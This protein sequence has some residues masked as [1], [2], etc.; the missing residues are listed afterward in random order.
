MEG[1]NLNHIWFKL[2]PL[3]IFTWGLGKPLVKFFY[4]HYGG[5]RG[6]STAVFTI[7]KKQSFWKPASLRPRGLS[8]WWW[9][10]S[11]YLVK[12]CHEVL[13]VIGLLWML[14]SLAIFLSPVNNRG[15]WCNQSGDVVL[16]CGWRYRPCYESWFIKLTFW[17]KTQSFFGATATGIFRF[18]CYVLGKAS[19]YNHCLLKVR[20]SVASVAIHI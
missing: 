17:P 10:I 4:T 2:L 14:W 8:W 11:I 16:S 18:A 12:G 3:D 9:G 7:C 13:H 20:S 6:G 5:W 15:Y 19:L 1:S